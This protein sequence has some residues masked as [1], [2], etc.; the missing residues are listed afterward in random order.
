MRRKE[1]WHVPAWIEREGVLKLDLVSILRNKGRH[2]GGC[3]TCQETPLWRD[4]THCTG[5]TLD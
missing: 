5:K 1:H 2:R 4:H 3:R